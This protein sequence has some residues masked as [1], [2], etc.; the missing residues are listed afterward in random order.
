MA[1]L[2]I[3]GVTYDVLTQGATQNAPMRV[4]EASPSFSGGLLSTVRARKRRWTFTLGPLTQA[5]ADALD[6]AT[7]AG[8]FLACAGDAMPYAGTITCDVV[9]GEAPYVQDTVQA[10]GFRRFVNVTLSEV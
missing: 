10:L 1:F 8:L 3:G 4:G 2:T 6:A 7:A 5:Q 9:L